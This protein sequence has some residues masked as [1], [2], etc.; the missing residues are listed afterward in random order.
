[1]LV[2]ASMWFIVG[3][4]SAFAWAA[5]ISMGTRRVGAG[6]A[7]LA[8][9]RRHLIVGAWLAVAVPQFLIG[10]IQ[11]IGHQQSWMFVT[12]SSLRNPWAVGAWVVTV[13]WSVALLWWFWGGPFIHVFAKFGQG[14]PD[15]FR[16]PLILRAAIT[17]V[18]VI[19]PVQ[20]FVVLANGWNSPMTTAPNISL[21]RTRTRVRAAELGSLAGR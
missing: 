14:L 9:E 4:L 3:A 16:H 11:I 15:R 18:L 1:M 20:T 8:H 6:S 13:V 19:A 2:A 10:L 7:S 17:A 21:Q 12:E 5:A